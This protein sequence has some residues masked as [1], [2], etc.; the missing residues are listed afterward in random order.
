MQLQN[1]FAAQESNHDD[2]EMLNNPQPIPQNP[3]T[4][5]LQPV[6]DEDHE[7]ALQLQRQF[8]NQDS[9]VPPPSSQNHNSSHA[10]HVNQQPPM[11]PQGSFFSFSSNNNNNNNGNNGHSQMSYSVT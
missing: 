7:I 9:A 6:I 1:Q 5:P 11:P 3:N 2:I 10:N 8:D 4:V